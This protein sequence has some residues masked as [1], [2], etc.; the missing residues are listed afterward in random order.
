MID[1]KTFIKD[2]V[3]QKSIYKDIEGSFNCPE[4]GCFESTTEG[5]YD[6]ENKKVYWVCPKGHE[7]N[8]NLVYE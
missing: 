5:K 2:T 3:Q 1:P 8:A 7:G 4:Q 6:S